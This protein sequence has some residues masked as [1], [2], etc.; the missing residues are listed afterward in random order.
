P[1]GKVDREKLP[2]LLENHQLL[3]TIEP[4]K[5]NR[6]LEDAGSIT[7]DEWKGITAPPDKTTLEKIIAYLIHQV[8]R[9]VFHE[10]VTVTG[11]DIKIETPPGGQSPEQTSLH[12][13]F[14]QQVEQVPHH[15]A[16]AHPRGQLTYRQLNERVHQVARLLQA[17]GVTPGAEVGL[18]GGP[19]LETV[20]GLLGILEAG[21]RC[22]FIAAHKPGKEIISLLEEKKIA[23]LLTASAA[24]EGFH[25][26]GLQGLQGGEAQLYRTP[27]RPA[28]ADFDRLPLPDRS[29]VDYEK[30]S[31][32]IGISVAK[33]G[34]SLQATRG[35]P[36]KCAYCHKIWPKKHVFRSAEHILSE[37]RLYYRMGVRRF[38]FIDD[39]FNLNVKNSTRF[40]KLLMDNG[41][42]VQLFFPNG[43]RGD[44]LT[45]EYIDL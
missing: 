41:L 25:F 29:L 5:I 15:I 13:D 20:T 32:Y 36:F 23:I 44:V 28:I 43:L 19:S 37:V 21:A 7:P 12:H 9:R 6:L 31:R 18:L 4:G 8:Q 14:A 3:T 45:T 10:K 38:I 40:F 34:I 35:C 42:E 16:L 27:E 33:H 22:C 1:N 11:L 39:V 30:Y 26:T 2:E 17:R 24:L